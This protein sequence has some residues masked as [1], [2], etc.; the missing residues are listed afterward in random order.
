L[1]ALETDVLESL[2]T[3]QRKEYLDLIEPGCVR[4]RE[5]GNQPW[6]L[7]KEGRSLLAPMRGTVI[8][9][10]VEFALW[11]E[12]HQRPYEADERRAVVLLDALGVHMA[13]AYNES[14]EKV[15]NAVTLVAKVNASRLPLTRIPAHV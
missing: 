14:S 9:D 10:E 4:G 15:D 6:T 7:G 13:G 2:A 1:T 12:L 11:V 3:Q 5:D 8:Q